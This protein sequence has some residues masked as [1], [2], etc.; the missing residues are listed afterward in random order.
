MGG[1]GL[2]RGRDL[3]VRAVSG[4][5]EVTRA[6]LVVHD[7]VAEPAVQG[8]PLC[9]VQL[10]VRRRREQ[11]VG[12]TQPP[13]VLLEHVRLERGCNAASSNPACP[14]ELPRRLRDRRGRRERLAGA[15]GE[16]HDAVT[17]ELAESPGTGSDSPAASGAPSRASARPSSSA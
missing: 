10:P 16:R 1:G 8:A 4:E 17:E 13:G 3:G 11:G 2:E 15:D 14:E 9:L 12:E 5:R 6:L 7:D